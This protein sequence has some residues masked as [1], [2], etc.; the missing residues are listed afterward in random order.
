MYIIINDQ[1]NIRIY[2]RFIIYVYFDLY[3]LWSRNFEV[4]RENIIIIKIEI[5]NKG[6]RKYFY[7][8]KNVLNVVLRKNFNCRYDV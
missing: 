6:K 3:K 1:N 5:I 7:K 8:L 4:S 2:Y